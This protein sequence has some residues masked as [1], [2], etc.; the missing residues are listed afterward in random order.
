MI[1]L[2]T[3]KKA[4][5]IFLLLPLQLFAQ[6]DFSV[7]RKNITANLQSGLTEAA[8]LKQ[9][10]MYQLQQLS[11]GSWKDINY[12]DSS[13]TQWKP[14]V[15]LDRLQVF[16][17]AFSKA[18]NVYAGNEGLKNSIISGLRF[19]HQKDPQSKNWWHN[20]I[21]TPQA[22]GE[23]ML[24]MQEAGD[25]LPKSLQDS[26][27]N[28]MKRGN[29]Y[30]KTGANKLDIAIHN[31]YRACI[32]KSTTLMDSAASEAFQ[33]IA[34][35]TEEGLQYDNSYM[36]HGAQL[37]ISSY[38]LVFLTGEYK[39]AS[40]L[41]GTA[42]ALS[43]DKL[44]LLD[45][46]FTET[47]L[48]TIRGR[49]IDFNTEGRGISRPDIL[50]KYS[51]AGRK[52]SASLM[53]L[54]KQVNPKNLKL[55]DAATKRIS[56]QEKPDFGIAASHTYFW[57]TDYTLHVQPQYSFNVRAVSD[58]TKRTET[59]NKEN[60]L[61]KCLADG[62]TNIQ[63]TGGEYYNIM[64]IWEW[65]KIPG[66][67]SR[68]YATDQP[69]TVQW[70]E[71]GSTNF[72][73]GVSDGVYGV[74]TYN[75]DYNDVKAKKSYFFFDKEVVCLG[76]GITSSSAE[77]ITTTVN[78]SWLV[79]KVNYACEDKIENVKK[80]QN[81]SN[82]SWIWHDSTGYFFPF[83]AEVTVSAQTQKGSWAAINA[84]RSTDEIKGDVF[85]LWINHKAK[86]ANAASAY[87]VV[88]DISLAAMKDFNKREV[89]IIENTGAIQA[90]KHE[91]LNMLQIVFN[92][93]GTITTEGLSLAVDKPCVVLLKAIGTSS[94]TIWVA[95]PTQKMKAVQLILKTT[96]RKEE[97]KINCILP[98]GNFA[99]AASKVIL[100]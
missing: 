73:G 1:N 16:T 7:I 76:A 29:P 67:T 95:D 21:A 87:I 2:F 54:A 71:N 24:L 11:D 20:E 19:W 23:I 17:I 63:R 51:I 10:L 57:K 97:R 72:V 78:Q 70:G 32:I 85:K 65:D 45:N 91:G 81:I 18:D 6:N 26:L 35:T 56:E 28:R 90:V 14:A 43:G 88:P 50:D 80:V 31:L 49:Y 93:A 83:A 38:G 84:S 69:T 27:V 46:Y 8:M 55:L 33:P 15:H 3:I 22:L 79:G 42:F 98:T 37:Q 60:I 25:A 41:Q 94:G 75:M 40:W 30:D 12:K 53:S 68:D 48:R 64:P 59:G 58:R 34:F 39:V 36:Q 89:K 13:I 47:F 9:M 66:T 62:S 4:A 74:T 96:S 100:N 82:P 61:G 5:V 77:N 92:E 44:K 52:N 99:G 86:P